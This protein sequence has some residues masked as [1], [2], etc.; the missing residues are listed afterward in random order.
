MTISYPEHEQS[1]LQTGCEIYAQPGHPVANKRS[2]THFKQ[3]KRHSSRVGML[4]K[5]LPVVALGLVVWFVVMGV[6]N[7][8]SVG[9]IT[10]ESTGISNGM[11]VM[12][13]PKMSGFNRDNHP[14]KLSA[15]RAK[16]D[17]KSPNI[18]NMENLRAAV[19]MGA[20]VFADIKAAVGVYNSDKEWLSLDQNIEINS[21]DGTKI[22]LNSAEIDLSKGRLVSNNP[23]SVSTPNSSISANQ[24]E[25]IDN[26]AV[27]VFTQNVRMTIQPSAKTKYSIQEISDA[28]NQ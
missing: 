10:V 5:A 25:V 6:L 12:E 11:L 23:V 13:A 18:I 27:V 8:K 4:K 15:S 24:V 9:N 14:Y 20:G 16:Q 19:P 22:L 3:A 2:D 26:G 17:I 1:E 7:T 21:R 28:D